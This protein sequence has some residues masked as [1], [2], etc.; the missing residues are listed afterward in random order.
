M[1]PLRTVVFITAAVLMM[2]TASCD[3]Q[4][5]GSG[6]RPVAAQTD[7]LSSTPEQGTQQKES[8]QNPSSAVIPESGQSE[9]Y[10][11][12]VD[13]LGEQEWGYIN[14]TGKFVIKPVYD[15]AQRFQDN[16]LAIAGK[17]GKVGLIDRTGKFV[18]EPVYKSI[19]EFSEGL[20][21]AQDDEGFEVLDSSGTVLSGNF[22]HIGSYREGRAVYGIAQQDGQV[23]Y[24]YLDENGQTAIEPVYEFAGSFADGYAVV[25][26][27]GGGCLLIDRNGEKVKSLP[28]SFVWDLSDGMMLFRPDPTGKLGYLNAKGGVEI[29]PVFLD[30]R[31]FQHGR[32]VVNAASDYSDNKYGLIDKKGNYLIKPQ[33]NDIIQLDEGMT[34]LGLPAEPGEPFTGSRYA[35][36]GE[37]GTVL[38]DFEFYHVDGFKNGIAS[39]YNNTTTFFV[40]K[41]GKRIEGLPAADGSGKLEL[42]GSLVYADI[43]RRPYY[44]DKQGEVVYRP[45]SAVTLKNGISVSE[46]KYK[47]NRNY[48]VYYPVVEGMKD[49]KTED[50]VNT[51]LRDMWTVGEVKPSD[52]LDYSYDGDFSI[53]FYRK[54]L[55]ELKRSAYDFPFGAAHGMPIMRYVHVDTV[56]GRFYQLEELFRSDSNYLKVLSEIVGKQIKERGE[57]MGIWKDSYKGIRADQLF[58]LGKNSLM[59]YFEPYEIGPYASGFPTFTIPFEEISDIIDKKG[60]FWQSFN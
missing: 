51:R 17:N 14:E 42:L 18:A 40:D 36:A 34:A 52:N 10:P 8:N 57:D 13:Y 39:V 44:M 35:L 53:G 9:V 3:S 43:D 15:Q 28:Y 6:S 47:P 11:A 30:A 46:E 60:S 41:M 20:A 33:Y 19:G 7:V 32:A 26:V 12:Q 55:L 56:T 24:G 48:L 37:D 38:T 29:Q 4:G 22:Q 49:L 54:N 59:L 58:Y 5:A 16:G 50:S 21:A 2:T 23:H 1:K 31:S 27:P 45:S 25:K